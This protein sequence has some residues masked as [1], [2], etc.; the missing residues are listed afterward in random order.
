MLFLL[1]ENKKMNNKKI[2][3]KCNGCGKIDS[4]YGV[5]W[6]RFESDDISKPLK[7]AVKMGFIKPIE[8]DVCK[9]TGYI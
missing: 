4:S 6:E 9:G 5:P 7:V 2:C 8:C 3:I 1:K